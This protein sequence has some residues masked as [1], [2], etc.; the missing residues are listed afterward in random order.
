MFKRRD[1][2]K[3]SSN[4]RK[5]PCESDTM[6]TPLEAH[7]HAVVEQVSDTNAKNSLD[8]IVLLLAPIADKIDAKI[9]SL[10]AQKAHKLAK[11]T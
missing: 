1:R 2:A 6:C 3:Q 11:S 10:E 5:T 9:A 8:N 7:A 4:K